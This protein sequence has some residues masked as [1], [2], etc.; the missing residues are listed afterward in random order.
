MAT[1]QN[2]IPNNKGNCL[3]VIQNNHE[4]TV[5]LPDQNAVV[6]TSG[7]IAALTATVH[8]VEWAVVPSKTML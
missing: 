8:T 7:D 5:L 2:V 1:I 6:M 4:I 3:T